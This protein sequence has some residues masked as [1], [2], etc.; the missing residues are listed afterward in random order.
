MSQA[1][2]SAQ[3]LLYDFLNAAGLHWDTRPCDREGCESAVRIYGYKQL[4]W[5]VDFC[6]S[7]GGNFVAIYSPAD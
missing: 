4:D 2:K 5:W 1:E 6:F 7:E 3:V